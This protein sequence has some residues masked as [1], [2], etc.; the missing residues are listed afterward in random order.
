MRKYNMRT[1][2]M[3]AYDTLRSQR[4]K[5]EESINKEIEQ[6]KWMD[7]ASSIGYGACLIIAGILLIFLGYLL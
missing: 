7:K 6:E 5:T 4:Q 2:Y 3:T 1:S